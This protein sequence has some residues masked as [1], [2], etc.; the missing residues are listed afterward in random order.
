[1]NKTVSVERIYEMGNYQN[2]K[3]VD[4][5]TEIPEA[6]ASNADAIK[7]VRYLQLVDLEWTYLQYQKLRLSQPKLSSPEALAEAI[8]FMESERTQTFENLINS[9]RSRKE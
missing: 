6:I 7:L 8:E 3:V 5:I 9:I 1:M 4:T 2:L